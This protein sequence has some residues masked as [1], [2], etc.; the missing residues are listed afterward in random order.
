MNARLRNEKLREFEFKQRLMTE[1]KV[2]FCEL[3]Q[4]S[5]VVDDVDKIPIESLM[6]YVESSKQHED[7]MTKT[8]NEAREPCVFKT[9]NLCMI[10]GLVDNGK[11]FEVVTRMK[12]DETKLSHKGKMETHTQLLNAITG[13][14][15]HKHVGAERAG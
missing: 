9:D 14:Q 15:L 8:S 4:G 13:G 12:E 5:F 3:E 11:S 6:N 10:A 2:H 7:L 1:G